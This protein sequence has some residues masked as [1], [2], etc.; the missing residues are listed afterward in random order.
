MKVKEEG[1]LTR[2]RRLDSYVNNEIIHNERKVI[3]KKS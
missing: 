3:A 2:K 1:S